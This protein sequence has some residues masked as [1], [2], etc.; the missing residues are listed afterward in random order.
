MKRRIGFAVTSLALMGL[1]WASFP[2]MRSGSKRPS[3]ITGTFSV[4]RSRST[5]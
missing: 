3:S 4:R 2:A 1:H 5:A